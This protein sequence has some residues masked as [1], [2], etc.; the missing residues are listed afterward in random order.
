M[1]TD[2]KQTTTGSYTRLS[3]ASQGIKNKGVT[4]YALGVGTRVDQAELNEIASRSDY[5]SN[6]PSFQDLLSFSSGIRQLFCAGECFHT[7][8]EYMSLI[9]RGDGGLSFMFGTSSVECLV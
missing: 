8:H 2:G 1:I 9:K 6:A 3:E 7:R 5:V 4:V